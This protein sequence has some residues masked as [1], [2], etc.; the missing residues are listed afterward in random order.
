MGPVLWIMI[1]AVVL[2]LLIMWA[3]YDL[4]VKL[5]ERVSG[6]WRNITVQLNF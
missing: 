4:L 6:T 3:A 1:G 5:G 2:V